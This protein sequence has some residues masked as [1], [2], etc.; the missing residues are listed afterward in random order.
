M[1]GVVDSPT[2]KNLENKINE[3]SQRLTTSFAC[4]SNV[5]SHLHALKAYYISFVGARK[6]HSL[7]EN[8]K[9]ALTY[10]KTLIVL[11]NI[12]RCD[13][14]DDFHRNSLFRSKSAECWVRMG[15]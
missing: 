14:I 10:L 12:R 3:A 2:T 9:M 7:R 1:T 13:V 4:F 11:P 5:L 8:T 6:S 15:C